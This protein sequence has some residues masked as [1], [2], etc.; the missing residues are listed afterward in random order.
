M[1]PLIPKWVATDKICKN[2][3]GKLRYN[4]RKNGFYKTKRYLCR[5]CNKY[6]TRKEVE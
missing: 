4:T 5:N 1:K 2:C 3:K 6:L